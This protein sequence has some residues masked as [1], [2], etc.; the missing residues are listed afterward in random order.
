MFGGALTVA[1]SG[2]ARYSASLNALGNSSTMPEKI[3]FGNKFPLDAIGD[4]KIVPT[5][6]LKT[7]SGNLNY[8]ILEDGSLVVGKS[9]HTSLTNNTS[10]QAAGEIQLYNGNVKWLDNASGHYQPTGS[11]IQGIAE[12]A[13]EGIGLNATGKFQ[14]KVWM[15]DPSLPRG[16]KWVKQ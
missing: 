2:A 12:S 6:A 5:Q 10:V 8:V 7:M 4:P 15:T 3:L 11:Q 13:F 16:G 9:P 1:G 14:F